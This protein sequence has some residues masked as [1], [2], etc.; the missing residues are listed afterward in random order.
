EV[1]KSESHSSEVRR[2]EAR[3]SIR[4]LHGV[5]G[6]VTALLQRPSNS[7]NSFNKAVTGPRTPNPLISPTLQI[8]AYRCTLRYPLNNLRRKKL[9]VPKTRNRIRPRVI[10][11]PTMLGSRLVINLTR[12]AW[13]LCSFRKVFHQVDRVV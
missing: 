8:R 3:L 4:S 5:R 7:T 11:T 9:V 2:S 13:A 1:G 10:A 12:I 6:P